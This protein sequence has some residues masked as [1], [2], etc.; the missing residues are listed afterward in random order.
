MVASHAETPSGVSK[1]LGRINPKNLRAFRYAILSS[2]L[3]HNDILS[4]YSID[5][6][7]KHLSLHKNNN[8]MA[9]TYT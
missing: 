5:I 7:K 4:H 8:Y 2:L 6:T 1:W 3:V 9:N